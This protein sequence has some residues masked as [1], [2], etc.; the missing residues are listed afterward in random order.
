M[1]GLGNG[2]GYTTKSGGGGGG[3]GTVTSV[4]LSAPSIF[5]VGGSPVTVSGTLSLSLASQ[6]ANTIFAAP[7]GSSGTPTFRALVAND[8]PA[9]PYGTVT[10]VGMSVPSIFTISGAPITV[11]GT[12]T[13]GLDA[14]PANTIFAGPVGGGF[15]VPTFRALVAAD[16][17][18]GSGVSGS[19][20]A[21]YLSKFTAASTIADSRFF[22][23]GTY[24]GFGTTDN[25][26][27]SNAFNFNKLVAITDGIGE[28]FLMGTISGNRNSFQSFGRPLIFNAIAE[29]V[30]I[31]GSTAPEKLSVF[32][33][34]VTRNIYTNS[35]TPSAIIGPGGGVG[36]TVSIGGT[37]QAGVLAIIIGTGALPFQTLVTLTMASFT[38]PNGFVCMLSAVSTQ[39]R[40]FCNDHTIGGGTTTVTIVCGAV[41]PP[42][43]ATLQLQYFIFPY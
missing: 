23:N 3:T 39:G 10:S 36:T 26:V 32:G 20:T 38:A 41:P 19:G 1:G 42:N 24:G 17:P 18:A 28:G 11:S 13:I 9:L 43:G 8:I 4:G 2:I 27:L 40:I 16:L 7:N 22:D 30:S 37:N 25:F 29:N 31:G 33:N 12:I 5:T 34:T 14:E 35:S 21:N 6:S 15:G